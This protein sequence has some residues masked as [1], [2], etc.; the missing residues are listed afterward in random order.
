MTNLIITDEEIDYAEK[1]L[2]LNKGSFD[3][4]RRE[5]IKCMES[6]DVVACPGSGKTTVLLAK[7]IIL[8]N[9]MPLENNRGICVLTHTNVAI[10]E[11]KKRLGTKANVLL[12]YPNF[13]GTIQSFVDKYLAIPAS[14]K[15]YGVRPCKILEKE[16]FD[17]KLINCF[18]EMYS[19]FWKS[20]LH[21]FL[22]GK[23]DSNIKEEGGDVVNKAK[24][25]I[26]K[27]LRLD[28]LSGNLMINKQGNEVTFIKNKSSCAYIEYSNLIEALIKQGIIS[29]NEADGLALR[30]L[31][32]YKDILSPLFN[33][34][35][36]FVF[37]DEMQDT[38]DIQNEILCNIFD[39]TQIIYQCFG[40]PNQAIYSNI[41][42]K[43]CWEP[44]NPM[45]INNS[46]RFS[47]NIAKVSD[48]LAIEP[49]GMKG[50]N[51][52]DIPPTIIT[53][54]DDDVSRVLECFAKLIIHYNLHNE[55]DPIF[56]AVGMVKERNNDLCI[57]SYFNYFDKKHNKNDIYRDYNSLS[58]YLIKLNTDI[59]KKIGVGIYY[60][61][62]INAVLK[63]L[64]LAECKNENNRYYTK[65]SFLKLLNDNYLDYYD[66]MNLL[67]TQCIKKLEN[68]EDIK[69]EFINFTNRLLKDIFD[70]SENK[71]VNEFY[72]G[73][74]EITEDTLKN[75][76]MKNVFQYEGINI[77]LDTVHGVK[78]ESHTATLYLETKYRTDSI[79]Y[80]IDYLNGDRKN[81]IKSLM[82]KHLK[83]A[84][85]AMTR[86]RKLLCITMK[87]DIYEDN[88]DKL[89][90]M[91]W[92][93]YNL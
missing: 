49:Y 59:V 76:E 70:V 75:N 16:E 74:V 3:T 33:K 29:Y 5:V 53:Y 63:I 14:I 86:P 47:N 10:N 6:R 50:L 36:A 84:Y 31:R 83:I 65:T 11:I 88:K 37:I 68:N 67:F 82:S 46:L 22:Y 58:N 66:E 17:I 30:Y 57:K 28:Y 35:F 44:N 62:F 85:V 61:R 8:A 48:C 90:R 4:Q 42:D 26:L 55:K 64:R 23:L 21:G 2:G 93:K 60:N 51:E 19:D 41:N 20:K 54:K 92:E 18:R 9:K 24:E 12:S 15:Y 81:S 73:N 7:L 1:V 72:N 25:E 89:K 56:K 52:S 77:E 40:D 80:I 13:I 34:R 71:L 43:G 39:K 78:G 38:K 69:N 91:G 32:Q 79:S 87:E 45:E 27:N